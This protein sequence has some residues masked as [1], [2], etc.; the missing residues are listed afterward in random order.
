MRET[1]VERRLIKQV[2]EAGGICMKVMPIVAGYPD[3]LVLLPGNRLYLVETKAPGGRLRPMQR[4]FQERAEAIGVPVAV[5][6][7]KE[8]VDEWV[9]A[10][11]GDGLY[12]IYK[13][14][15]SN[16]LVLSDPL[17]IDMAKR[18]EVLLAG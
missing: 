16:A 6:Y 9:T 2:R 13:T 18:L 14:A 5:L 4:V 15:Q 7:N 1:A 11:A 10:H 8:Q 12:D 17:W 3:R